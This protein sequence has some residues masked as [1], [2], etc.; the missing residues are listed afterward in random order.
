[1]TGAYT[2]GQSAN[3]QPYGGLCESSDADAF[4]RI[5][6]PEGAEAGACGNATRCVA[7]LLAR[8]TGRR[9]QVIRTVA[10]NLRSE[11]LADG[12]V[13]SKPLDWPDIPLA[14][15]MGTL[16][17]DLALGPV[18]DPAAAGAS[19][20][21]SSSRLQMPWELRY[22]RKRATGSPCQCALTSASS[23]GR[24]ASSAVV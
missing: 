17:L 12:W 6:N 22:W 21:S 19:A 16:H 7:D 8:E 9:A 5:R 15:A 1:M 20:C 3:N 14:R 11:A 23:R 18:A 2:G 24:R 13:W 4:M 10:G